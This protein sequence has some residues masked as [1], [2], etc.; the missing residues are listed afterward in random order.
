MRKNYESA[1]RTRMKFKGIISIQG[2]LLSAFM[3][4]AGSLF[5]ASMPESE[6]ESFAAP[7]ANCDVFQESN[8]LAVIQF[9]SK[10]ASG[11]A[12]KQEGGFT[13]L[14][15]NGKPSTN[16][17]GSGKMTY[18]IN[19]KTPGLYRF[20]WR[21]TIKQGNN[22]A[23]HN[24]SWLRFPNNSNFT[25]FGHDGSPSNVASDLKNKKNVVF[26]G[27]TGMSPTPRGSSKNGFFKIYI[28]STS[29]KWI[30]NTSDFDPHKVY[31]D[32]KKAG[33]YEM[34]VAGRSPGHAI[35]GV[36]LYHLG[37]QGGNLS[38]GTLDKIL[39]SVKDCSDTPVDPDPDPDPEPTNKAPVIASIPNQVIEEGKTLTVKV[40][41]SD[42]DNDAINLSVVIKRGGKTV[43]ASNYNFTSTNKGKDGTLSF[44]TKK[45]DMGKV[46][47]TVKA[48]DG[49]ASS[50]EKFAIEIK[51]PGDPD[52]EPDPGLAVVKFYLINPAT[53]KRLMEIK[54]GDDIGNG[55]SINIEAVTEPGKAGSVKFRLN[56]STYSTE[57]V[58]P[59]AMGGDSKGNFRAIDLKSGKYALQAIPYSQA[60]AKGDAGK[61]LTISFTVGSSNPDPDPDPDPN[62]GDGKDA[63]VKLYLVNTKDNKRIKLLEEGDKI[64]GDQMVSIEAVTEPGKVGSVVFK[65]NGSKFRTEN[66]A[67]YALGGD[68]DGNFGP[69]FFGEGKNTVEAIPYTKANG[70]GDAGKSLKISFLARENTNNRT[71]PAPIATKVKTGDEE[72]YADFKDA[73]LYPNPVATELTLEY[74][75]KS[76]MEDLALSLVSRAGQEFKINAN[77]YYIDGNTI[78][79]NVSSL[80]MSAGI[81]LLRIVS[82]SSGSTETY[83]F[84]KR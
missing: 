35:D 49:K 22:R 24:D 59:Y 14:V 71:L 5:A 1:S 36:I 62:P 7:Q 2:M 21:N 54:Q 33:T 18:K 12:K 58:A 83:R 75:G 84:I 28:N 46:D 79:V 48:G 26:P 53:N 41:A 47:V 34:E 80:N 61:P 57:N 13:Y 82:A 66:V 73:N 37:K 4:F 44:P 17:P 3:L 29:W 25:F 78:K 6:T 39:K 45:G 76:D 68:I 15:W 31:V 38:E 27:G 11:W 52:P 8:G 70:N 72:L 69:V 81:Y 30:A 9:E 20:V 67:P 55:K 77:D 60:S 32:V 51:K 23:E 19:F 63:V 64:Y 65:L 50:E 56:G 16:S 43:P 40:S 10:S 74:V 42:P